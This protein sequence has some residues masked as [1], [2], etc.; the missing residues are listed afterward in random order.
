MLKN[1]TITTACRKTLL[2]ILL[3]VASLVVFSQSKYIKKFKPLADS[4]SEK[5]EIPV[6][7]IL[8][9]AIIESGAGTSRNSKLLHNHFGIVGKNKLLK[10][11]GIKSRYKQ[12][13]D[14]RASY[15]AFCKLVKKKKF[16]DKL[17]GNK[18][19]KLWLEAM[20]QAGYSEAPVEWKQN[21]SAAIRKHKLSAIL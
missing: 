12:F 7:V 4:L 5:Y 17:K 13:D 21:I 2:V 20:T 10:E 14:D 6:A 8:G 18:D 9:V 15:F 19:Y 16:Y 11:K 3:L 1:H